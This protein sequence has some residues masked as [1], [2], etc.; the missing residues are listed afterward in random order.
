M[1]KQTKTN[2]KKLFIVFGKPDECP[3]CH[4][5]FFHWDHGGPSGEDYWKCNQCGYMIKG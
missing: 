4:C 3:S 2:Y 1:K 5:K